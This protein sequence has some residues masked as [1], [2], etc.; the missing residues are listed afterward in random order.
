MVRGGEAVTEPW[1][2]S[3]IKALLIINLLLLTFAYMTWV[4]RKVLGGC[5]C[6][7]AEPRRPVRPAAADRRPG[8]ADPQGGFFPARGRRALHR[9]AGALGLHRAGRVRVIPFGP[10]WEIAAYHVDGGRGAVS[11]G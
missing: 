6:A 7:T 3:V 10:G 8:Q 11:I 5:S 4:E 2:I 9:R 1:W